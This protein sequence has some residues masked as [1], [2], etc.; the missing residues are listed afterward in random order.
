MNIRALQ[1]FSA[2]LTEGTVSGAA[3]AMNLSQPAVSRLIALLESEL[4]LTLFKR[5]RHRLQLSDE[6]AVFAKEA[7]R[8]LASLQEIPRIA[9]EIRQG[10]LQRLRVVTMPRAALSVVVPAVA[11]LSRMHPEVKVSLDLRAHR[12][13]ETWINGREYDLGF[14]N[15]PVSHRAAEGTPMARAALQVLLP[16]GHPLADRAEIDVAMLKDEILVQQFPGMLLRGQVD[17]LLQDCSVRG[18]REVLTNSS[19]MQQ[20]LVAQGAGVAIIDRLSTLSMRS[21][22]VVSRPLTPLRWVV[23][24]VIR[25]RD[26]DPDPLVATLIELFRQQVGRCAVPGVI[27]PVALP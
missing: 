22:Q 19:Q 11:Q 18:E 9:A 16:T 20:H 15:V 6:G 25:H 8:I 27:E 23:F 7:R 24:G 21:D 17:A 10:R 3:Q 12:D 4:N 1:A 14:G 5:E 2:V 13:L 26:S